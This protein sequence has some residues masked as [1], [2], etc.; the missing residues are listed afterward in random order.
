[1]TGGQGN[2]WPFKSAAQLILSSR[3]HAK[4]V[5]PALAGRGTFSFFK[6][7]SMRMY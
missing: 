5:F 7:I 6:V 2:P 1:L 4:P 3:P